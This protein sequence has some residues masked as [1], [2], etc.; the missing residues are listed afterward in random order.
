MSIITNNDLKIMVEVEDLLHRKLVETNGIKDNFKGKDYHYFNEDDEE[1]NVW[2]A[3]W[4]MVEKFINDKQKANR[5]SATY[6]KKNAE[7]HRLSNNLYNARKR[8]DTK[9]IEFYESKLIKL[10][11]DEK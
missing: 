7:Y 2:V 9:K 3:Y 10:K 6:N 1:Y 8:N 5:R 11:G 4:N